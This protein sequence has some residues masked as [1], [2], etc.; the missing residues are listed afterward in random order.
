MFIAIGIEI[1]MI[2]SIMALI[3]LVLDMMTR[4]MMV[5]ILSAIKRK[6]RN[7]LL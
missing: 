5:F 6:V 2:H 3:R 1:M 4:A 7:K